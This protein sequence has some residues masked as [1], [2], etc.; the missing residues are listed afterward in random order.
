MDVWWVGVACVVCVC[1]WV[2]VVEEGLCVVYGC[3]VVGTCGL[4][5]RVWWGQVGCVVCLLWCVWGMGHAL[6]E[7]EARRRGTGHEEAAG[8]VGRRPLPLPLTARAALPFALAGRA[9][10]LSSARATPWTSARSCTATAACSARSRPQ[11]CRHQSE[12]LL[13]SSCCCRLGQSCACVRACICGRSCLC[14][15]DCWVPFS[16]SLSLRPSS[17]AASLSPSLS[18]SLSCRLLYRRLGCKLAVG[19]PF[20]DIAT[21]DSIIMYELPAEGDAEARR[22][23]RRLQEVRGDRALLSKVLLWLFGVGGYGYG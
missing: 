3:V 23:L 12:L 10:C 20:K 18:L 9:A 22:A 17:L 15:C 14:G 16:G 1:V 21:S 6:E 19:M 8:Q 2:V 11:T 13:R 7:K 4:C 5:V